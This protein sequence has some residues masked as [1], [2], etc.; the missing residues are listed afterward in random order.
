M[1]MGET[2]S[3]H[4]AMTNAYNILIRKHEEKRP[5]GRPRRRSEDNVEVDIRERGWEG[6]EWIDL[7]HR[8]SWPNG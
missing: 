6:V 2:C 3:V 4:G 7:N 5:L 8:T 1:E